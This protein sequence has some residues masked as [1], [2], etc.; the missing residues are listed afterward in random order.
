MKNIYVFNQKNSPL[1][2]GSLT[3]KL[4][5]VGWV[6]GML[7]PEDFSFLFLSDVLVSVMVA[8]AP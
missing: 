6:W 7:C 4:L 8:C 1:W 2:E 5:Q 3:L